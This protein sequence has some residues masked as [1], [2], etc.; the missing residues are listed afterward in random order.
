MS[1]TNVIIFLLPPKYL[2]ILF[3]VLEATC[4]GYGVMFVYLQTWNI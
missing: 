4:R 1:K 3:A 2:L